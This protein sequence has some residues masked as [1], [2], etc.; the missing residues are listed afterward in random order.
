MTL[1]PLIHRRSPNQSTLL[2]QVFGHDR[3]AVLDGGLPAWCKAG[4]P[5]ESGP[6]DVQHEGHFDPAYRAHLVKSKEQ[7]LANALSD[8]PGFMV[9]LKACVVWPSV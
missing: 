8:K 1:Q 9:C 6:A 7:M 2:A 3:V 5:V 4:Y